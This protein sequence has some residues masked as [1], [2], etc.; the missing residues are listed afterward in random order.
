VWK[1]LKV[2]DEIVSWTSTEGRTRREESH[3]LTDCKDAAL[4]NWKSGSSTIAG[5]KQWPNS[6]EKC[7]DLVLGR[8]SRVHTLKDLY[9]S[10]TDAEISGALNKIKRVPEPKRSR[11]TLTLSLGNHQIAFKED[12]S[13]CFA[14]LHLFVKVQRRAKENREKREGRLL[15]TR[16][17]AS[18][19]K[20][21]AA[22][23][24]K[25]ARGG[26]ACSGDLHALQAV[27][28]NWSKKPF[29]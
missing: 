19:E 21:D 20:D 12:L 18:P 26:E 27:K 1:L 16:P 6:S 14:N 24:T 5:T 17:L 10:I 8:S 22:G 2:A 7:C 15:L 3:W 25:K 11:L 28:S 29:G 13:P 9:L 4:L 23:A